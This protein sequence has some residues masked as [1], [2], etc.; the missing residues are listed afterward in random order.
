LSRIKDAFPNIILIYATDYGGGKESNRD[1]L[2][3]T[4]W[5]L[6]RSVARPHRKVKGP[7]PRQGTTRKRGYPKCGGGKVRT[8]VN[9]G[10]TGAGSLGGEDLKVWQEKKS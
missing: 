6:K 1:D 5:L 3:Q 8:E 4:R 2:L 10:N 9:W 7:G